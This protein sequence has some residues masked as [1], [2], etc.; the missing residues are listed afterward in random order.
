MARKK[1]SPP[2][3]PTK[4]Q[5]AAPAVVS[6]RRLEER[7]ERKPITPEQVHER[8]IAAAAVLD[9]AQIFDSEVS[10]LKEKLKG[11]KQSAE[12]KHAE[13]DR[14]VLDARSGTTLTPYPVIVE[15]HPERPHEMI[16]WRV[17]DGV[18]AADILELGPEVTNQREAREAQGCMEVESRA[19][20]PEELD[21]AKREDWKRQNP[22]LPFPEEATTAST[23]TGKVLSIMPGGE[24]GSKAS[25]G[26][27]NHT[28]TRSVKLDGETDPREVRFEYTAQG[29]VVR[30]N[31]GDKEVEAR[32]ASDEIALREL[33]SLVAPKPAE[34]DAGSGGEQHDGDGAD[35]D[36]K[37]SALECYAILELASDPSQDKVCGKKGASRTRG[38]CS[39]HKHAAGEVLGKWKARQTAR[40]HASAAK[41]SANGHDP[42]AAGAPAEL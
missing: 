19:C 14:I 7:Q 11:A 9:E 16:V 28:E 32:G 30:L 27:P 29:V 24:E 17:P 33:A 8:V 39:D 1:A 23:P 34:G 12:A 40:K 31:I 26:V 3:E 6:L 10:T 18:I 36:E 41:A 42:A 4:P 25:A 37:R 21:A 15:R 2:T 35:G 22:E 38:L 5:A 13:A 20:T